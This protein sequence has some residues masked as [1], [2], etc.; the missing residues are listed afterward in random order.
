MTL[1]LL[2]DLDNTLLSNG[3]DTFIPAYLQALSKYLAPFIPPENLLPTLLAGTQAMMDN[4][5][6]DRTLKD[7][8]DQ[9]FYPGLEIDPGDYVQKFDAFYSEEF[10]RLK[11]LTQPI[12]EAVQLVKEAFRRGYT[13]GIAT[14]PLFPR[15]AILQRLEWAGLSP[16]DYPFDL[17]P[18]YEDFHFS[19]PN[20]S[21]FT[22]ILGRLGWPAGP[23]V[24]VGDDYDHDI[25][26]PRRLGFGN[27]QVRVEGQKVDEDIDGSAG[28]GEIVDL[29][30]W[31]DSVPS[32]DLHIDFDRIETILAVLRAT[33]AVVDDFSGQLETANWVEHPQPGEWSFTEVLCHLRDVDAEVNIPRIKKVLGEGNPFLPGIDSDEWAQERLYYCQSGPDALK[34]FTSARIQLLEVLDSLTPSEWDRPARHAIFGPTNLKELV[35]IIVG[36]DQVHIQQAY[37]LLADITKQSITH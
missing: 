10:P 24:M 7:A 12:P 18:S 5:S 14:N 25:E 9:V 15:A 35:G 23:V 37:N 31:I 6:P 32:A 34:D 13:V 28:Q 20:P 16:D 22:E 8:F 21:F 30:S 1:T 36:H 4:N 3:M 17:I 33:P 26:P 29:I 19:K 27:Y 2:L 11:Q